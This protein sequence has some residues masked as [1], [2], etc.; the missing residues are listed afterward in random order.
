GVQPGE[1]AMRGRSLQIPWQ[2]EDTYGTVKAAYRAESDG[3]VRTRLHG[4]WLLRT[5]WSLRLVAALPG[6]QYR[7][8]QRGVAWY[9]H[10][11]LPGVRDHRIGVD[12]RLRP[13][14]SGRSRG[15]IIPNR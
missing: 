4:L 3:P 13:A 15:V 1:E 7:P 9:R 5:G 12:R 2:A 11:G 8:V 6:T 10:R 14:A